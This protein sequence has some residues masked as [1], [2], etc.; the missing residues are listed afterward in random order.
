MATTIKKKSKPPKQTRIEAALESKHQ[1]C[2]TSSL[3]FYKMVFYLRSCDF[4]HCCEVIFKYL[5]PK[6]ALWPNY[7]YS[8]HYMHLRVLI[9][10][11]HE[12]WC[13]FWEAL[14]SWN[15]CMLQYLYSG[16]DTHSR[17]GFTWVWQL[18]FA[19]LTEFQGG[20][21]WKEIVPAHTGPP[22]GGCPGPCSDGFW[23]SLKM[24]NVQALWATCANTQKLLC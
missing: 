11:L 13:S 24:E 12:H 9:V 22:G 15:L 18:K 20:W 3:C 7:C 8:Y 14:K 17:Q 19:R 23:I 1:H 2:Y 4:L 21:G 6:T 5:L 10:A 16:L